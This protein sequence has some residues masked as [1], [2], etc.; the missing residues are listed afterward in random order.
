M[1]VILVQPR[2]RLGSGPSRRAALPLGLLSVATPLDVAGFKVRIIDQQTEPDWEEILLSELKTEPICV[3][4]SSMTGPEIWGALKASEI[5]KGHSSVPVV[6]GGVHASL[7]PQQTLENQYVDIVVKGEGEETFSELVTSLANKK[8]LNTVQGIWYK[9]NGQLKQ[10][11]PRPFVDLNKLPP[12]SY[13]LVDLHSHLSRASKRDCLRFETSRG[14]PSDCAF[15]YNTTFN[16]KRWRALNPEETLFRIQRIKDEFNIQGIVLSD[17]N[18]FVNVN[19]V[20]QILESMIKRKLD[21]VWA[22]GDIRLD[23][24]A[25]MDDDFFSLLERSGCL[26]IVIGV[27]TGSQRVAEMMRKGIDISQAISVNRRLAKYNLQPRYC[28]VTGI[29]GETRED[30]SQTASLMLRLVEDNPKATLGVNIFATYPGTELFNVCVQ[31]GFQAPQKL[32][33]WIPYSWINRRLS[34]PW[35]TPEMKRLLRMISFCSVF[36]ARDKNLTLFFEISRLTSIV[37]NLYYPVAWKRMKGLH[38]RL[39]PELKIAELLGYK[40]W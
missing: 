11:T 35:W 8:P 16:Q 15:C 24:V 30:L 39:L 28:F 26:S 27:E 14:C 40:G 10:N 21:M 20:Y 34:Y 18:F 36:L 17:D 6:W 37:A 29:P 33:E 32:E 9:E 4:M 7:L 1:D 19:R 22:A 3:G 5:V 25:Q 23:T 2:Y 12:L 13:H 31:H 38:S